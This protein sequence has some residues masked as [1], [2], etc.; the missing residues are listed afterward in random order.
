MNDQTS[1][2]CFFLGFYPILEMNLQKNPG[3]I[4]QLPEYESVQFCKTAKNSSCFRL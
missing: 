2:E 3:T 1:V 4:N